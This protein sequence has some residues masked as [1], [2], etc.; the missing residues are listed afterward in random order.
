MTTERVFLS[1]RLAQ[2]CLSY[3]QLTI[4]QNVCLKY[5]KVCQKVRKYAICYIVLM[6]ALFDLQNKCYFLR[7][8]Q[9]SD[10]IFTGEGCVCKEV[11]LSIACCCQKSS[12]TRE[13]FYVCVQPTKGERHFYKSMNSETMA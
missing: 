7:L 8:V 13:A 10:S 9:D 3:R 12:T 1:S 4:H 11:N 5:E 6:I 2:I